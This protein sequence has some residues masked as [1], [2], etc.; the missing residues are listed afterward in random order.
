MKHTKKEILAIQ[1]QQLDDWRKKLSAQCF[2][3]LEFKML[4]ENGKLT[5]DSDPYSIW[6]GQDMTSF[7]QN[8]R[9]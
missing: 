9:P 1:R 6:R 2:Y 7:V 3:D 5:E 8:W 4:M